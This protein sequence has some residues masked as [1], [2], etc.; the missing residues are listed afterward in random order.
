VP[1]TLKRPASNTM[2]CSAMRSPLSTI[3]SAAIDSA[4]P[5]VAAERDPY[6]PTPKATR[7]VSPST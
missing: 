2:S 6:V 4:E 5:P 3:L 1:P 7:S